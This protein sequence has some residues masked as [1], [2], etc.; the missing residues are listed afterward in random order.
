M[1]FQKIAVAFAIILLPFTLAAQRK[2]ES[3]NAGWRFY[4]GD[5]EEAKNIGYDDGKW[6]KVN[7]PHSWNAQDGY[8]VKEYY[9]GIG[10][11][12]KALTIPASYQGKQ[13]FLRFE[14]ALLKADVYINGKWVGNHKGGYTAFGFDITSFIKPGEVNSL[15]VKVDNSAQEIAP[16][17]GDFT[18]WGGIYRDVWLIATDKVHFD[19]NNLGSN[20]VFIETP[21]VSESKASV[22]VKGYVKSDDQDQKSINIVHT[23]ENKDGKVVSRKEQ[24]LT[25]KANTGKSFQLSIDPIQNPK[26]WS[27]E[28]PYLYLSR[29]TIVD[30]GTKKILDEVTNP[31]GFRW[32]KFDGKTGF[33]LN[34][35]PY[36]LLGMCR[37][38][39]QVGLG[40]ALSDE[41]HRRD[42]KLIKDMG[43]N[44]VRI[45]HYPQDQAIIEQ[46]D[47]LG[48]LVWEE[49]PV[50]DMVSVNPEFST[51]VENEL[52][53]MIRQH[54]NHPSIIMW[55]YMN[56]VL[57]GTL[58]KV[59]EDKQ[60][61]VFKTTQE[62][63]KRLEKVL[64]EED[65][66]RSSVVAQH[67]APDKYEGLGLS[68]I[69][70]VLGWNLY[71]GW[72]GGDVYE[73]GRFMD[74]Q[75]KLYPDR[76]HIISEYG[77]GSDKRIHSLAP[78]CFD[79]SMEYQ[80]EYHEKMMKMIM[81]RPYIAGSSLWNL[82]DFGSAFREESMSHINNKGI[83]YADRTPK[84]VYYFYQALF[85]KKPMLYVASRDWTN[86]V[87]IAKK[88]G[89]KTVSQ[90]VKVYSNLK[91]VELLLDGRSLGKKDVVDHV[92]VWDVAFED[93]TQ[94]LSAKGTAM[95]QEF[96]DAVKITFSSK[97]TYL[98]N[99][100]DQFEL[101]V[102]VGST[103]Y[104]TDDASGFT[105]VPEKP[106][107]RGSWGYI[108]GEI[109]RNTP[110]RIGLQLEIA[111]THNTPLYQTMRS[112]IEGFN[113]DVPQGTY[114]VEL[115]F[116]EPGEKQTSILNDIGFDANKSKD[117]SIF[118]LSIN[119]GQK[120]EKFN[121]LKD[122]GAVTAVSKKYIVETKG[123]EGIKVQFKSHKGQT[124]L[125]AIKLRKIN[126]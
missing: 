73:F 43:A 21:S 108:G 94:V 45:S 40:S 113:F 106:Y 4:K 27:P 77:A 107:E 50:V 109:L 46:C 115:H 49:I 9:R 7:I 28:T 121:I 63:A 3:I 47:K 66:Y 44:F 55:G 122:Y 90:P 80:Q 116:A 35:K 31:L 29:I 17:S 19:M 61:A 89:D 71:Q 78:E 65:K 119:G 32:F 26:L 88:L 8:K 58:R 37:H 60:P 22:L 112:G 70:D 74:K 81:D 99:I 100:D 23:I 33:H 38:Q 53:E 117:Y 111:A 92:A 15:S 54:Y 96:N 82:I 25:L 1:N 76:P 5:K 91:N 56:E 2:I 98:N 103:S 124:L 110:D 97:P 11:Y 30:K 57:L 101:G 51:N 36:K 34:G 6:D 114:E 84:D 104:F 125:S 20:G 72:Y 42:M 68:S 102:N 12:R 79:F 123:T 118:D 86:R 59:S 24:S 75:H 69:S 16:L 120:L 95:E 93:G 67:E 105:W 48:L 18:L 52:R 85:S 62:L 10:W 14:A 126:N 64:H 41:L 13:L 87:G 83:V 39:D